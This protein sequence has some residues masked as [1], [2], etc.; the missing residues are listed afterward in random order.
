MEKSYENFAVLE[1]SLQIP[2]GLRLLRSLRPNLLVFINI[3]CLIQDAGYPIG[4]ATGYAA[5]KYFILNEGKYLPKYTIVSEM[6]RLNF[7]ILKTVFCQK[8]TNS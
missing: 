1:A 8:F 7:K 5:L 6:C 3:F 4:Y 2:V